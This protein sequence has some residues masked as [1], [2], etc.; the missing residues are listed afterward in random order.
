[1]K[2][3][4]ADKWIKALKSGKYK[5]TKAVLHN[6]EGYC[7]LGV[8]CDL[9][10]KHKWTKIPYKNGFSAPNFHS[11]GN[12]TDSEGSTVLPTNVRVWA[13][14][15]DNTG[16]ITTESGNSSLVYCNDQSYTFKQMAA[17]IKKHWKEL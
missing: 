10:P 12:T 3:E 11:S 7:C 8:L 1:M 16:S 2:K 6:K 5:Q 14:M 17:L 4:I 13:D 15:R 9:M